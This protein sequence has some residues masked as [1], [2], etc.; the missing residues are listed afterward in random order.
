MKHAVETTVEPKVKPSILE[1]KLFK[2]INWLDNLDNDIVQ[3]LIK[4]NEQSFCSHYLLHEA[5][6]LKI[7]V[8]GRNCDLQ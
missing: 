4:N 6:F 3:M 7:V 5:R 8:L 2:Q 1:N